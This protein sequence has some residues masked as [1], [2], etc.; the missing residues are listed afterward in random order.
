MCMC[1][2]DVLLIKCENVF[3][4]FLVGELVCVDLVGS[5]VPF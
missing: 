3:V 4:N 5:Q 2:C 1:V